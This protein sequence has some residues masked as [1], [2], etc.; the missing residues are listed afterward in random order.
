M[1]QFGFPARY[2]ESCRPER[3]LDHCRVAP[4]CIK[5]HSQARQQSLDIQN[6]CVW[7]ATPSGKSSTRQSDLL[8]LSRRAGAHI[9]RL[10][11]DSGASA[12]D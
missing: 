10:D 3:A 5:C 4:W 7:Y 6:D 11:R 2:C 12:T 9:K 1:S 8:Q